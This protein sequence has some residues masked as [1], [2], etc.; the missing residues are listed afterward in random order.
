MFMQSGQNLPRINADTRRLEK[1]RDLAV[2]KLSILFSDPR[3]SALIR[4]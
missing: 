3:L 4:G 1:N 2:I